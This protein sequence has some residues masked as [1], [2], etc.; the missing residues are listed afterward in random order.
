[1]IVPKQ[2]LRTAANATL[3]QQMHPVDLSTLDVS[4]LL[5]YERLAPYF[6]ELRTE[7]LVFN[8]DQ[9]TK[10]LATALNPVINLEIE[11]SI[12]GWWDHLQKV[13]V[14]QET[15]IQLMIATFHE[16]YKEYLLELTRELSNHSRPERWTDA[17][18]YSI[19]TTEV[20]A[21][22]A[23]INVALMGTYNDL[24]EQ[25]IQERKKK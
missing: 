25:G 18:A 10:V 7:T 19:A 4:E 6:E 3:K 12:T 14:P 16:L 11:T 22:R 20:T 1:M 24:I 5:V 9:M 2:R 23:V 8:E 17:R 15:Y 21:L 13:N